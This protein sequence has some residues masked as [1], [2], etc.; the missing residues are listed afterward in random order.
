MHAMFSLQGVR[1]MS[2]NMMALLEAV[3]VFGAVLGF[4]VHQLMSVRRLVKKDRAL[5]E[6]AS[7]DR[8]ASR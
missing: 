3:L 2:S 1:M 7:D 6:A 5:A 4:G 8:D